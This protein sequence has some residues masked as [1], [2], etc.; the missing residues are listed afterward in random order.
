LD[1]LEIAV[2][3]TPCLANFEDVLPL[4]RE[5]GVLVRLTSVARELLEAD[6]VILAGSKATAH[7]LRF[8]QRTGLGR[9]IQQRAER[10]APVLGIC[11]GAQMLGQRIEDPEG[12]ES[13]EAQ[14]EALGIL[15]HYTRYEQPK[16]TLQ[17]AGVLHAFDGNSA[18]V[19]GFMLHH[20]RLLGVKGAATLTL[21][22]GTP[23]GHVQGS[24]VASMMHRLFDEA[25][26]RT[27][28][29][30]WLRRQRGIEAP[31]SSAADGVDA[32]AALADHLER[33]LAC[34]RL[35]E[36]TQQSAT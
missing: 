8:L 15:P 11:G 17:C 36:L 9:V 28:L 33:H 21:D 24:V 10:G 1:E 30:A 14:L 7:D 22:D 25:A 6:L 13:S 3:D 34:D 27:A 2:V 23:E 32:Y 29:L 19:A 31:P 20:G 26:A 4:S 12:V 16:R 35:L 18:R 5:P